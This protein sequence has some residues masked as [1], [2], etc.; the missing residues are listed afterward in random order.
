M[1]LSLHRF[2]TLE[3]DSL[4][5]MGRPTTKRGVRLTTMD[6]LANNEE[7][8]TKEDNAKEFKRRVH[9]SETTSVLA[10]VTNVR[11]RPQV[12][13]RETQADQ[14]KGSSSS[15]SL[16]S[17]VPK[18]IARKHSVN[19]GV[20]A[21]FVKDSMKSE[22]ATN[23]KP[24]HTGKLLTEAE[25]CRPNLAQN[26]SIADFLAS[27]E[28]TSGQGPLTPDRISSSDGLA[29][30]FRSS[31]EI[32]DKTEAPVNSRARKSKMMDK[33]R[34]SKRPSNSDSMGLVSLMER[35]S[36]ASP[37]RSDRTRLPVSIEVIPSGTLNSEKPVTSP[38]SAS[39]SKK[40]DR[41]KTPNKS[42]LS[43]LSNCS[44]TVVNLNPTMPVSPRRNRADRKKS[45]VES[46]VACDPSSLVVNET[47]DQN[48]MQ[49]LNIQ[50]LQNPRKPT[51]FPGKD[52]AAL[53][54][55]DVEISTH[56]EP[57]CHVA[58]ECG[59]HNQLQ[60]MN[61]R[62][63]QR[64]KKPTSF[65]HSAE[66]SI[67]TGTIRDENR[68]LNAEVS[69]VDHPTSLCNHLSP[70][71]ASDRRKQKKSSSSSKESTRHEKSSTSSIIGYSKSIEDEAKCEEKHAESSAGCQNSHHLNTVDSALSIKR[72]KRARKPTAFYTPSAKTSSNPGSPASES[73]CVDLTVDSSS[74]PTENI[75]SKS[76]GHNLFRRN[77]V[78]T[79]ECD[80]KDPKQNDMSTNRCA[81][82]KSVDLTATNGNFPL[83]GNN[84]PIDLKSKIEWLPEQLEQLKQAHRQSNSMSGAFWE[85]V[86]A[87]VDGKTAGQC[88]DQWYSLIKTPVVKVKGSQTS[89][90][91]SK[92]FNQDDLFDSTPMRN[93][94]GPPKMKSSLLN[95]YAGIR[96]VNKKAAPIDTDGTNQCLDDFHDNFFQ[97]KIGHKTYLQGM[98]RDISKEA[99]NQKKGRKA[100]NNKGRSKGLHSITG[101]IRDVDVDMMARLTP[102]GSFRYQNRNNDDHLDD[103]DDW[104]DQSSCN[105][106]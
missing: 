59:D 58:N 70:G 54:R 76:D 53:K 22:V 90:N 18:T 37:N 28:V 106:F 41:K 24:A 86:A 89:C 101:S 72:P 26:R 45:H 20:L 82:V 13:N 46:T 100:G 42:G 15:Y 21:F 23:R 6:S 11:C 91:P 78:T 49:P 14:K 35:M 96:I 43:T 99:R 4:A 68:S 36:I 87:A 40:Q 29:N 93:I 64:P 9:F 34:R 63:S 88:R 47:A 104:D 31:L 55:M 95:L 38:S 94:P 103:D 74:R 32:S 30:L 7:P 8:K 102:G 81:I 61:I 39:A 67:P 50:Q 69:A 85:Q 5:S 2:P 27:D 92:S 25:S 52:S 97:P 105:N 19:G 17:K 75:S 10:S 56:S 84:H 48:Q 77:S 66:E 44:N 98:K 80:K 51:K 83:P 60:T 79:S 65:F 62:R 33:I 57:S 71:K 3:G 1:T 16:R 73:P 12:T